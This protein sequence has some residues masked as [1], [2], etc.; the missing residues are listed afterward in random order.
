MIIP[1]LCLV[2]DYTFAFRI[3]VLDA[4]KVFNVCFLMIRLKIKKFHYY[5][6][7]LVG[8]L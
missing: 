3:A 6:L 1:S 2:F 5:A 7:N 8:V 4:F